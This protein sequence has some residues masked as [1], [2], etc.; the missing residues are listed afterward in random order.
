[1]DDESL[2]TLRF[3][4]SKEIGPKRFW[5]AYHQ[6]GTM[7]KAYGHIP[8]ID[9]RTAQKEIDDTHAAGAQFI[10]FKNF[11]NLLKHIPD[12]PP[13]LVTKGKTDLWH[14][15]CIAIVGSRSASYAG[16]TIASR[17]AKGLAEAGHTT[18]SGLARGIDGAAHEASLSTGTIAVIAGGIDIIYP[19]EHQKLY[20]RISESGL[21]ITEMGYGT[22]PQP[23]F[24][25]RRNR[26]IAALSRAIVVI[27]ASK[28]SGSIITANY[29]LKY[30]R[31]V[32]AV[33]GTPLDDR[34]KGSNALLRDGAALVESAQDCLNILNPN[35]APQQKELSW[36]PSPDNTKASH[37]SIILDSLSAIPTTLDGLVSLHPGVTTQTILRHLGDLILQGDVMDISPG[38]HYVKVFH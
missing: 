26:L 22:M 17:I 11:S 37:S 30:G 16:I 24:F 14:Q 18:V 25:P 28:P 15:S 36:S 3:W 2:L 34:S 8:L 32:M 1:M 13:L 33:P 20:E 23:K 6:Y 19:S 35:L 12:P 21:I 9:E 7:T 4:R 27:E 10:F 31:D 38:G 5:Q 29:A